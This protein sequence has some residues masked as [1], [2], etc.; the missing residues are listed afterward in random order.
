MPVLIIAKCIG[1][2]WLFFK[3]IGKCLLIQRPQ[4]RAEYP[5]RYPHICIYK[6]LYLLRVVMTFT[7]FLWVKKNIGRRCWHRGKSVVVDGCHRTVYNQQHV[8]VEHRRL[9]AS[10]SPVLRSVSLVVSFLCVPYIIHIQIL[11]LSSLK[12]SH[13]I[14]QHT[15]CLLSLLCL[16]TPLRQV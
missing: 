4:L 7:S 12:I 11:S 15:Y 13:Q 6:I 5:L 2:I 10:R 3:I 14:N 8:G 1:C 16:C 9:G